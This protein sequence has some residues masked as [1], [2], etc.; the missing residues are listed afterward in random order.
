MS[1]VPFD[2]RD[3]FHKTFVRIEKHDLNDK[4]VNCGWLCIGF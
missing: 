4:I 2:F 3:R 1:L